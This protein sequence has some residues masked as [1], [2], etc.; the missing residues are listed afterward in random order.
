MRLNQTIDN[1]P[2]LPQDPW[3][4]LITVFIVMFISC[5]VVDEGSVILITFIN[6]VLEHYG[7]EFRL[8]TSIPGLKKMSG[9]SDLTSG[10]SKYVACGNCHSIFSDVNGAPSTCDFKKLGSNRECGNALYKISNSK[11]LRPNRTYVYNSLKTAL[12]KLFQRPTFEN[13]INKWNRGPKIAGTMFDV[14]DGRMW[15]EFVD[16]AGLQFVAKERSL[17]LTLNIDWFQPFDGVT[18]SCGAIYL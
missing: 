10:V 17:L 7:E 8:P 2:N 13:Q 18:Y 15:K 3:H 5:F 16:E 1:L 9:F 11:T 6:S 14:Y 12:K 4:R